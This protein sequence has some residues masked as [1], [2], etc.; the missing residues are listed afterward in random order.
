M[1]N[2]LSQPARS[3]AAQHICHGMELPQGGRSSAA[4][5]TP[6]KKRKEKLWREGGIALQ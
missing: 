1:Y 4:P 6:A 5:H 2:V 3:P